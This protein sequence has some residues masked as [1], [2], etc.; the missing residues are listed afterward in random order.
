MTRFLL[1]AAALAAVV[2]CTGIRPVGP[3]A[4]M[5]DG[6]KSVPLKDRDAS[7]PS[8]VPAVKPTPP[9]NTI[10]LEDVTPDDPN[11]AARRL[12]QEL[13]ADRRTIP[14]V[15]VLVQTS[16]IKGGVRRE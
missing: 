14:A 4:K 11:A 1:L 16:R 6:P 13:D 12:T 15:P 10:G 2:G 9:S 7:E 3:L 5:A 8:P